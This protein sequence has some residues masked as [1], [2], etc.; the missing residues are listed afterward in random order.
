MYSGPKLLLRA[1]SRFLVLMQLGSLLMSVV[2]VASWGHGNHAWWNQRDMQTDPAL[3][4]PWDSGLCPL[5]DAVA[6]ELLPPWT[7]PL[8]QVGDS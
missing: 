2:H 4:W 7:H 1:M 5:L 8:P 3:C 6:T